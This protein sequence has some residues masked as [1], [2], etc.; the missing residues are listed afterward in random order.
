MCVVSVG[1]FLR[2]DS[3]VVI[4]VTAA[5]MSVFQTEFASCQAGVYKMKTQEESI[6]V[7]MYLPPDVSPGGR[8]EV[9]KCEQVSNDGQQMSLAVV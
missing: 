5:Q 6:L 7:G 8:L 1:S 4:D 2:E 3:F 9:N